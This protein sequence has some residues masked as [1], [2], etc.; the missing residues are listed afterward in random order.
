M[1][2]CEKNNHS[3]IVHDENYCPLCEV[4][5]ERDKVQ[6]QLDDAKEEVR[7]L[8]STRQTN[9]GQIAELEARVSELETDKS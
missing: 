5:E 2:I 1:K 6:G 9:E 7:A 4:I 3:K 8:D